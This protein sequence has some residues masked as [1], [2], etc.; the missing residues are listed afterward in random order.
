MGERRDQVTLQQYLD[1]INAQPFPFT[2]PPTAFRQRIRRGQKQSNW[3]TKC[4]ELCGTAHIDE[5]QCFSK[6]ELQTVLCGVQIL[7]REP[8]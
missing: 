8:V 6:V 1:I 2:T 5:G 7:L 3:A 4:C